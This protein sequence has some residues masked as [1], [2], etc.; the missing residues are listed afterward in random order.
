MSAKFN[1]IINSKRP[2]L[3]DFHKPSSK[4]CQ[5]LEPV[6][7][8]VKDCLEKRISIVKVNADKNAGLAENYEVSDYPTLL[9]FRN[10]K[11]L[12]RQSGVLGKE[13]IIGKII[14]KNN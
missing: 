4:S 7:E 14:E 2:V 12:W 6:L 1:A 11:Q 8:Q 5:K 13:E 3:V 9:L 10:G